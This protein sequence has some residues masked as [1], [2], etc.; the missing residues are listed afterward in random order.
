MSDRVGEFIRSYWPAI[1]GA[2]AFAVAWGGTTAQIASLA[3]GQETMA[4]GQA[5]IGA[6]VDR[7]AEGVAAIHAGAQHDAMD[8]ADL[9][10]R[11]NAIEGRRFP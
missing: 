2:V 4:A 9:R 10:G 3:K 1:A 8:I 7:L 11:V 6:K 5:A